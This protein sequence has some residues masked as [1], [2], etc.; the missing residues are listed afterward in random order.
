LERQVADLHLTGAVD[1]IG[2]VSPDRVP[3]L[4]NTA[5]IV[6]IPSRY[7]GL[8]LMGLEAALMARPIV[9]SRIS[10][11]SEI[12]LHEK[13]GFLVDP[14]DTA[15]FAEAIV[16]LLEHPRQAAQMGQAGRCRTQELFS[17][18]ACLEAYNAL[19]RKLANCLP[20]YG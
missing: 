15:G 17:W 18:E 6:I 9:G 3:E 11:L 2:W 12:V 10:G 8:P 19:Y 1:F 16:F 13:T 5:T 14:E 7:E 20:L 4:I